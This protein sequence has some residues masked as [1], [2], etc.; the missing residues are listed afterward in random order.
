ML[1]KLLN[2]TVKDV[3]PNCGKACATTDVLC[4]N[5]G[6]NLDALFEQLPASK[7]THDLFKV[8]SENLPFLNW[9][10]PLLLLLSPLIV[11]LITVLRVA[12][13]STGIRDQIPFQRFWYAALIATLNSSGFLLISAIPLFLCTTSFIRAKIGQRP[14]VILAISFSIL[15]GMALWSGLSTANIWSMAPFRKGFYNP[16]IPEAWVYF[17]IAGGIILLV[18]NLMI[19]IE[20]G[21]AA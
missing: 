15:S 13:Y 18:L 14:M 21:K 3:C 6:E 19:A 7:E 4:P 16:F 1:K 17:V 2:P 9:L 11:S 12:V 8:V 10:T 5:C 20:K